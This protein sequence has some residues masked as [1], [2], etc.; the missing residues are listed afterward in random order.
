MSRKHVHYVHLRFLPQ[1]RSGIPEIC[2]PSHRKRGDPGTLEEEAHSLLSS[3]C[4]LLSFPCCKI[5]PPPCGK[6]LSSCPVRLQKKQCLLHGGQHSPK[7]SGSLKGTRMA[8]TYMLNFPRVC[9]VCF[10]PHALSHA[11]ASDSLRPG[12]ALNQV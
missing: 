3:T 6:L 8:Y 2:L 1:M 4:S 12:G 9:W 7:P 10:K 11:F 5:N